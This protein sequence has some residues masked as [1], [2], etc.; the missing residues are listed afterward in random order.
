MAKKSVQLE[1]K[2]N[3]EFLTAEV[4]LSSELKLERILVSDRCKPDDKDRHLEASGFRPGELAQVG[5]TAVQS[6]HH[7]HTEACV[8]VFEKA[9]SSLLRV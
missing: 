2:I 7:P 8:Y 1:L 9:V 4:T 5:S 6:V 3:K